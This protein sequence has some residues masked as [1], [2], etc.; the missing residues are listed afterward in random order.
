MPVGSGS[1]DRVGREFRDCLS[2]SNPGV[3]VVLAWLIPW[4]TCRVV[5]SWATRSLGAL[6]GL[7]AVLR[8]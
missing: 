4:E 6:V 8:V 3:H 5:I 7:S 1:S 2:I